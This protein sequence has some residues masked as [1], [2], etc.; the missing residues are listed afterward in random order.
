M[1]GR[2][3]PRAG[4]RAASWLAGLTLLAQPAIAAA[5]GA[6]PAPGPAS[7]PRPAAASADP[8]V[9]AAG[10]IACQPPNTPEPPTSKTCQQFATA[11]LIGQINP[12]AVLAVGDLQ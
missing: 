9:V 11:D 12:A 6:A 5:A 1:K 8:V 3:T 7:G 4:I 2:Q 10:D